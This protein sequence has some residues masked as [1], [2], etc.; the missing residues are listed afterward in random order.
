M[1]Q[2]IIEWVTHTLK[3]YL[4]ELQFA[5]QRL[6]ILT[7]PVL[8]ESVTTAWTEL[9][10]SRFRVYSILPTT[11]CF[12]SHVQSLASKVLV[13]KLTSSPASF[14]SSP[15]VVTTHRVVRLRTIPRVWPSIWS[16]RISST[17]KRLPNTLSPKNTCS[18]ST[19]N[20]LR[21]LANSTTSQSFTTAAKLTNHFFITASLAVY[22]TL[23]RCFLVEKSIPK[24]VCPSRISKS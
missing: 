19:I 21:Q 9:E 5:F 8:T 15:C 18:E 20:P 1:F 3:F 22:A 7:A 14:T 2:L 16:V 6:S 24:C 4:C 10:L 12:Q 13:S 11:K 17:C 23:L